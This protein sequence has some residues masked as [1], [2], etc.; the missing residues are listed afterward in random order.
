MMSKVVI[1]SKMVSD[2]EDF[3]KKNRKADLITTYLYYL[4]KK[5]KLHPVVF[6]KE[7][8]IYQSESN[9]V[10]ALEKEGKLWRETEIKIQVGQKNINEATRRI[11]ICPYSGKVFGDN[12][13]PNPQDAIYD[14]VSKCPENTDRK[15]GMRVKKFYV[16]EDPEVIKNYIKKNKEPIKKIVYTSLITGKLYND[17]KGVID[18]LKKNQIRE[19]SLKEVPTQNRFEIQEDFLGFI[20]EHLEENKISQFVETLSGEEVF[21]KHVQ[22]W[23]EEEE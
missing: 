5:F 11:Y 18:D 16:S 22:R 7:K 17:K 9:L 4:E 13:H 12:T 2:L 3:L 23:M 10:E 21:E 8:R 20:Q 19:I 6:M 1:P 15:D 14:W